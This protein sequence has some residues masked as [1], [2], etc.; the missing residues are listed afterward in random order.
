LYIFEKIISQIPK[1]FGNSL[2]FDLSSQ[3]LK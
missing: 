1:P 2:I 3:L